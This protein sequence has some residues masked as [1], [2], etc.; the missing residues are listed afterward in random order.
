M[1]NTNEEKLQ[2]IEIRKEIVNN[3]SSP[4]I[5]YEDKVNTQA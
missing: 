5:P 1:N 3:L 2:D 4:D